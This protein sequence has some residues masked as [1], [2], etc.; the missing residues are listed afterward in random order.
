[1]LDGEIED[2]ARRQQIDEL[3]L[4]AGRWERCVYR[5][6]WNDIRARQV[7]ALFPVGL[8]AERCRTCRGRLGHAG[9]VAAGGDVDRGCT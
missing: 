6:L 5:P 2:L 4:A 1:M 9:C 7:S 3:P 8:T